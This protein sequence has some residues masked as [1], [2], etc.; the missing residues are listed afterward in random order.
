M[1]DHGP[2]NRPLLTLRAEDT[3]H[4]CLCLYRGLS[5]AE[6]DTGVKVCPHEINRHVYSRFIAKEDTNYSQNENTSV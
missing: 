2:L 1:L 4:T 6:R 3:Y 5:I